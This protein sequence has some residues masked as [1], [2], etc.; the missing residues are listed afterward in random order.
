LLESVLLAFLATAGLFY[1]NIMAALVSG[2]VVGLHFSVRDAGLVVSANVYG[3]A[4]GALVAALAIKRLPWR[5]TAIVV[6]IGLATIDLASIAIVQ[7]VPLTVIR[8]VHGILG[9]ILV[10]VAFAV[11]A[12]TRH[13]D[14]NFGMLLV[15][16]A[17][18]GSLGVGILPRMVPIFGAPVLFIALA[19]FSMLTLLMVPFLG[20][21]P[22]PRGDAATGLTRAML[23]A[24]RVTLPLA[25]SLGAVFLFQSGNMALGAYILEL[26]RAY[27]LDVA[28][29]S[30]ALAIA[31]WIGACSALFVVKFGIRWGRVLPLAIGLTITVI[32]NAAYHWSESAVVYAAADIVTAITWF[33][34]IPYLL[35]LCAA[36]DRTGRGAALAGFA[37]KMGLA[38]GPL[39]GSLVLDGVHYRL[40]INLSVVV[41]ATAAFFAIGPA[42]LL[43]RKAAGVHS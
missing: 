32:G 23:S 16:A 25:L 42:L 21:Y 4:F 29:C 27:G 40:L 8:C 1:V 17:A 5:V 36:V 7:P 37:S 9:G 10:G 18:M 14:R 39:V 24:G 6:L 12:R 34:V 13:P 30:T 2:L 19:G 15:V 22:V 28:F 31:G 38:T 11:I 3:A 33:V 26:G 41:L 43:D 35:G 20:D